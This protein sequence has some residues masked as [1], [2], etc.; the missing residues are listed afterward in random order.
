MTADSTDD[1]DNTGD[2]SEDGRRGT[3]EVV[4]QYFDPNTD[5]SDDELREHLQRAVA[6]DV[7][8]VNAN[9]HGIVVVVEWPGS[10]D[11][12]RVRDCLAVHRWVG[13]DGEPELH[14]S[15]LGPVD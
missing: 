1:G 8:Y 11:G 10:A 5:V 12:G 15:Y 7:V 9:R 14:W 4:D 6:G 13:L 3:A 2:D